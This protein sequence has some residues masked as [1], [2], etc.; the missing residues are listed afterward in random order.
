MTPIAP[1]RLLFICTASREN[2]PRGTLANSRSS[3][4]ICSAICPREFV[5][6]RIFHT[7][8]AEETV[9]L[10]RALSPELQGAVLLIGD[11]G[12]G[13]TTLA[14]GIVEG[15]GVATAD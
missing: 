1:Q 12:A 3:P 2:L 5:P 4:Q 15:R 13:K 8:S 10:G 7:N 11:L 6:S 14:K 9:A